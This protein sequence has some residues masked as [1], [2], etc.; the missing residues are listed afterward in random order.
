[1]RASPSSRA[2][3]RGAGPRRMT[4]LLHPLLLLLLLLVLSPL[5]SSA[6][7]PTSTLLGQCS[8]HGL[9]RQIT[10]QCECADGFYGS[11]C[12]YKH[13]PVGK[14]MLEDLFRLPL[15]R[16]LVLSSPSTHQEADLFRSAFA[17]SLLSPFECTAWIDFAQGNHNAHNDH[18]CSNQGIC[19]RATGF[20]TCRPGWVLLDSQV[21]DTA[22][23]FPHFHHLATP[24]ASSALRARTW[25][26]QATTRTFAAL[27]MADA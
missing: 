23:S 24:A 25:T 4:S 5:Q 19:D 1:M 15:E 22:T 9:C 13:C 12:Q 11:A 2:T 14:G 10:H 7:C 17:P 26:A 3:D 20:C 18:E 16:S 21:G 6:Q 27:A 8:G